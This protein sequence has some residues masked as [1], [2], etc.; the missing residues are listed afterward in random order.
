MLLNLLVIKKNKGGIYSFVNTVNGNQ[1]IGSVK[2][3]YIRLL[4]HIRNKKN[5]I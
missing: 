1:Y 4:E 5:P 3:L 2:D